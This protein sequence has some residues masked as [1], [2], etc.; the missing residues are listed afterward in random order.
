MVMWSRYRKLRGGWV[1]VGG[2]AEH[3]PAERKWETFPENLLSL[4]TIV[5]SIFSQLAHF[6]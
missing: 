1:G 6:T 3:S 4:H 2:R 5:K